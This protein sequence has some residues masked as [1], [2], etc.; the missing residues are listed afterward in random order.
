MLC[1]VTC[2]TQ[3]SVNFILLSGL[4]SAQNNQ[5]GPIG[6]G[7]EIMTVSKLVKINN[8]ALMTTSKIIADV[9]KK[10]HRKVTRDIKEL[11]CSDEFRAAN[12]GLSSYTSPQNKVLKCFDITRDGMVF[13]CMGFTGKAAGNWKEKYIKAFNQMEKGLL[14]V[15]AEMTKLSNQ[16]KQIK[17]L[18]S[19]WSKFGHQINKQKKA[20][21]KSVSALVDKVQ[22]KLGLSD[23]SKQ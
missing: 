18:G 11:D 9:F 5:I 23:E 15:D 22:L 20:H 1:S 10:S 16:G 2:Q 19:E 17:E 13:L 3:M 7:T 8:G 6:R 4:K 21:D 14:N 12:F